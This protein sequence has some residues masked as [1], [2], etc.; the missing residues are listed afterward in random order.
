MELDEAITTRRSIRDYDGQPVDRAV[1]EQLIQAAIYAPS[2]KNSQTARYRVVMSPDMVE[3][4]KRECLPAYNAKNA[5][6]A[7]VLVVTSFVRGRS[8]FD[9]NGEPAN[10]LGDGWG[11]Y[12]L[13]L[14]NQTFLLKARDAGL[15]SLV[16]GLRDTEAL[17][18]LLDIPEEETVVSVIALGRRASDPVMPKRKTIED[19]ATFF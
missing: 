19:I 16:M 15:D 7:P 5:E 14:H 10:E 11:F 9:K 4:A 12:D 3:R 1:V 6:G 17:R 18:E 13:G 8:G 2:W